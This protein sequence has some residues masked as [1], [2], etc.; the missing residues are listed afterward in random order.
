MNAIPPDPEQ[1]ERTAR[2]LAMLRELAEIGMALAR[3]LGQ[4]ALAALEAP[5]PEAPETA[6]SDPV[7]P[8]PVRPDPGLGFARVAR[9]VRQTIALEARIIADRDAPPRPP[10]PERHPGRRPGRHPDPRHATIRRVL[11]EAAAADARGAAPATVLREID[12]RLDDELD[13]DLDQDIPVADIIVAICND[14]GLARDLAQ[15]S[16]EFVAI[17]SLAG[18]SRPEDDPACDP[19]A[20]PPI[21][22]PPVPRRS[23]PDPPP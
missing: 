15:Q 3:A 12:E 18:S 8:A 23:G 21:L 22:P 11:H 17:I 4:Q 20:P 2:H 16:D 6:P 13:A 1:A 5:A 7:H 9:A 10:R 19:S 14:L